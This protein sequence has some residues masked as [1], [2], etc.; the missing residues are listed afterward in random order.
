MDYFFNP[1]NRMNSLV[2]YIVETIEFILAFV[3]FSSLLYFTFVFYFLDDFNWEKWISRSAGVQITYGLF[4]MVLLVE[5]LLPPLAIILN[6]IFC[7]LSDT[8][9]RR[10]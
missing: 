6:R 3:S 1:I 4:P 7:A 5:I 10:N 2:I 8:L 9:F